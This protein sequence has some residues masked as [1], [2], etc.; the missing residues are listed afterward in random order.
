MNMPWRAGVMV[1]MIALSGG[2]FRSTSAQWGISLDV[3]RSA[4]GG[5]A[6]DTSA[7][8]GGSLRPARSRAL[9]LR[10]ERRWGRVAAGLGVRLARADVVLD[11][12]GVFAGLSHEF[13]SV[14]FLPEVSLQIVH[15]RRGAA[16]DLYGGPIIGRW[17]FE[18]F[19]GRAVPGGTAG[20]RGNFPILDRLALSLRIGGSLLRSVF[21]EG[22]VPAE[23]AIRPMRRSE[24]A[25]GLR[26][27]R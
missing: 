8:P 14:E 17:T 5:T 9:T 18:Q 26:Y 20:L 19:G 12:T 22:E 6:K 4:Y 16:L 15:T 24:I 27:G 25:V 11:A 21:R 10:L 3:Q 7:G 2:L 23:M 1:V 13:E